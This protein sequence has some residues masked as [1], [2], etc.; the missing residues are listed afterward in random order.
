MTTNKAVQVNVEKFQDKEY[1]EFDD[2]N[3]PKFCN[4]FLTRGKPS[5]SV[6]MQVALVKAGI[7]QDFNKVLQA[8]EA[9]WENISIQTK[10]K[11]AI[12]TTAAYEKGALV[13]VGASPT[14]QHCEVGKQLSDSVIKLGVKNAGC[15][16]Y[17]FYVTPTCSL[18]G[19][20]NEDDTKKDD[21]KKN[22][23]YFSCPFWIVPSG[24]EFNMEL[25]WE[26]P[27]GCTMFPVPIMKNKRQLKVGDALFQKANKKRKLN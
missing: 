7:V 17:M 27:K 21:T 12:V 8:N 26:T 5:T 23:S 24:E 13:F 9:S 19:E 4:D 16:D 22:K 15:K 3:T 18:P 2:A 11:K 20:A 10:P 14:V 25:G 6:D 1:K